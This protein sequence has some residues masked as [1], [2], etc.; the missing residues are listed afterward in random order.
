MFKKYIDYI[1]DNPE[2]LWFKRKL[3]GWGWVPVKWQG[4]F[5][6]L[7]FLGF[8]L[9]T[10]HSL[11]AS[12]QEPTLNELDWFFAK[13]A[14]AVFLLL[15]ICYKKGEK[16]RWQWGIPKKDDSVQNSVQNKK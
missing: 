11:G 9:W 3:Y 8:I 13:I 15:F 12:N 1:K 4:W 10:G 6:I 2:G 5:I 16:P 14:I 7:I